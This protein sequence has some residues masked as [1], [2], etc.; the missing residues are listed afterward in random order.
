[1]NVFPLLVDYLVLFA[2]VPVA[3]RWLMANNHGYPILPFLW[4]GGAACLYWLWKRPSFDRRELTRLNISRRALAGIVLRFGIIAVIL[5]A[6]VAWFAPE[7]LLRLPL[8]RPLL[9]LL[10]MFLYPALSVYPQGIIYRGFIFQR[11]KPLFQAPWAM[12]AASALAFALVHLVFNNLLAVAFTALAGLMFAW[13]YRRTKSIA[14]SS[15]E[16]ALYGCF[17]FTIGLGEF[18]YHGR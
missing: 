6:G 3:L 17:I 2:A 4:V 18:F 11:Y 13:T 7:L 14:I 10:I 5:G 9:W 8:T 1:M 12:T 15:L 16:H